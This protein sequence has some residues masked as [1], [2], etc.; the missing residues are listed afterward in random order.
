M[1]IIVIIWSLLSLLVLIALT[2]GTLNGDLFRQLQYKIF[3][4]LLISAVWWLIIS[5]I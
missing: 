3:T 2:I 4:L 5:V 1:I